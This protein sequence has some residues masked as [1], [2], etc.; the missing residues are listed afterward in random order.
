MSLFGKSVLA[1][2]RAGAAARCRPGRAR[3]RP[4][5]R[6][7]PTYSVRGPEGA[8]VLGVPHL[9]ITLQ[10]PSFWIVAVSWSAED[11]FSKLVSEHPGRSR[12]ARETAVGATATSL[13]E[14]RH[15]STDS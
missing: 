1:Q 7:G 13:R 11:E 9:E 14:R 15:P 10:W 3:S 5:S 6:L 12:T 8:G 2:K 4:A